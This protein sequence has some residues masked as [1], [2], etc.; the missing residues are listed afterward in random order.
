MK[1]RNLKVKDP[2]PK[3]KNRSPKVK[4][5]SLQVKNLNLKHLKSK[6]LTE[7]EG[8]DMFNKLIVIKE[9]CINHVSKRV[10]KY[11]VRSFVCS[12]RHG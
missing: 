2:N 1:N 12:L 7:R 3:V 4:N 10:M 5:R 8:S 9:D 6:N 11:F